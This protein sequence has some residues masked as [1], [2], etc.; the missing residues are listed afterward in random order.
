[1]NDNLCSRN[2]NEYG[3]QEDPC[4]AA[5]PG[6]ETKP[7]RSTTLPYRDVLELLWIVDPLPAWMQVR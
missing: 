3:L 1:M 6:E 2:G 4:D 7:S 5:T